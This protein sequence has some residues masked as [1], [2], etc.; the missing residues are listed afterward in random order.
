MTPN[1]PSVSGCQIGPAVVNA[2]MS[3]SPPH[4]TSRAQLRAVFTIM[5]DRPGKAG[6][7]ARMHDGTFNLTH[8]RTQV[9]LTGSAVDA[10]EPGW[11]SVPNQR[12]DFC[13]A[14]EPR[15]VGPL[16]GP[17][18]PGELKGGMRF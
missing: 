18:L 7:L 1:N 4:P 13:D 8:T 10:D 17:A 9:D 3:F 14:E 15:T 5:M 11:N 16:H 12:I 2:F 6:G